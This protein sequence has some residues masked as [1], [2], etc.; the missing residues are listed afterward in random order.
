M[1][2]LEVLWVP[3]SMI[4]PPGPKMMVCVEP[5]MGFFFRINSHQHWEPCIPILKDPHHQFLK[6]DS[7][8]EVRILDPDEYI[9]GEALRQ[10]GVIGRVSN[11]LCGPLLDALGGTCHSRADRNS[12]RAVLEPLIRA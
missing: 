11:T 12:I 10:N 8:V 3:D 9:V 4:E 7:F 6:W 1:R 2:P 5:D